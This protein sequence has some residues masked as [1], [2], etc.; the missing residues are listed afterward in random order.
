[1]KN[2]LITG[3]ANGIGK[4]TALR[5][6]D[7]GYQVF[8]L[9]KIAI[10]KNDPEFKDITTFQVDL[11]DKTQINGMITSLK[12]TPFHGIINNAA[13]IPGSLWEEFDFDGWDMA[14]AVNAT[15]LL[16]IVHGLRN[17]L[18]SGSSVINISTGGHDK[19]AFSNIGYIA[20]KAAIVSLTKSLAANLGPRNI[21]VN[22]IAPGWVTT[23]SAKPYIP[24][25]VED[26]TPLHRVASP[27]DVVDVMEYLLS[28]KSSFINGTVIDVDGGYGAIEYSLYALEHQK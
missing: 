18:D 11:A 17:N 1:V 4:A 20:S 6:R 28:D 15:A 7:A 5:L 25:A 27:E 14:I 26:I 3:I 9:D 22:A 16:R 8:G 12:D 21:R 19:A 2:V 24:K 13:E 23:D 10:N